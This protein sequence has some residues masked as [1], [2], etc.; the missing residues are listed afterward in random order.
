MFAFAFAG[1]FAPPALILR[2]PF[3]ETSFWGGLF[4]LAEK[5]VVWCVAPKVLFSCVVF[6]RRCWKQTCA[7]LHR[8]TRAA[9]ETLF[10]VR[11]EGECCAGGRRHRPGEPLGSARTSRGHARPQHILSFISFAEREEENRSQSK[12]RC[13]FFLLLRATSGR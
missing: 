13:V 10:P 6:K 9:N 2:P 5:I 3:F 1:P 8:A 7:K 11:C 4:S 12:G